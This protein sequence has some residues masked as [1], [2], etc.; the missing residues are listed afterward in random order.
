MSTIYCLKSRKNKQNRSNNKNMTK[1]WKLKDNTILDMNLRIKNKK[2]I[3][4]ML[5]RYY[6]QIN[7]ALWTLI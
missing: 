6:N 1:E 4:W 5:M 2:Y 7:N 3:H